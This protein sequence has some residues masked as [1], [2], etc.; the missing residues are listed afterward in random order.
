MDLFQGL[1]F[2]LQFFGPLFPLL[3]TVGQIAHRAAQPLD[4]L[5]FVRRSFSPAIPGRP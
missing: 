2:L 4:L 5:L 1:D 3:A